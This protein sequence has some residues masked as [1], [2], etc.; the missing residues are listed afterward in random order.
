MLHSILNMKILGQASTM[1][2]P[3]AL[4][5]GCVLVDRVIPGLP[6]TESLVGTGMFLLKLP[7]LCFRKKRQQVYTL[8][9]V[10]IRAHLY[11]TT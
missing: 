11:E 3:R 4:H 6:S 1:H 10:L 7:C 2:P 8:G 9:L 5:A